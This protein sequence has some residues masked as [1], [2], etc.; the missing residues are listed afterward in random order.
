MITKV[1]FTMLVI[2]VVGMLFRSSSQAPGSPRRA[3]LRQGETAGL[4]PR[5]VA[6]L[7]VGLLIIV[8]SVLYYFSWSDANQLVKLR[9]VGAN[10]VLSQYQAY[11]KDIDNREFITIDGVLIKLADSDRLELLLSE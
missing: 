11:Q 7:L 5:T 4:A 10:G 9:V 6:Y 1:L 2:I 8:S 3:S